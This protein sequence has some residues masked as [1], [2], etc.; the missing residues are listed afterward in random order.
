MDIDEVKRRTCDICL[1][2]GRGRLEA[3]KQV[4]RLDGE[5][6]TLKADGCDRSPNAYLIVVGSERNRSSPTPRKGSCSDNPRS[7]GL[8]WRSCRP[9]RERAPSL[10]VHGA[11][12]PLDRSMGSRSSD[13]ANAGGR[14]RKAMGGRMPDVQRAAASVELEQA[15]TRDFARVPPEPWAPDPLF[16]GFPPSAR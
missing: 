6:V 12:V 16:T 14:K 4:I 7:A 9:P 10:A 2:I 8:P 5:P 3:E 1:E 11:G 15:V 13:A